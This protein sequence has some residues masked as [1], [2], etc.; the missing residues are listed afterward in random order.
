M[1]VFMMW[2]TTLSVMNKLQIGRTNIRQNP[3]SQEVALFYIGFTITI[4]FQRLFMTLAEL[5]TTR[6]IYM[7]MPLNKGCL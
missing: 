2:L 7:K 5:M 3:F 6:Y 4:P 1:A